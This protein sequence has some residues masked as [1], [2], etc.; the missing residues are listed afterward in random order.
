MFGIKRDWRQSARKTFDK[1][2]HAA[3]AFLVGGAAGAAVRLTGH[4]ALA[5]FFTTT[6]SILL[7]IGAAMTVGAFAG[8]TSRLLTTALFDRDSRTDHYWKRNAFLRGAAVGAVGGGFGAG[9]MDWFITH[10]YGSALRAF[11][12]D[13]LPGFFSSPAPSPPPP[14]IPQTFSPQPPPVLEIPELPQPTNEDFVSAKAA[15]SPDALPP[16][17]SEQ[18]STSENTIPPMS[19]TPPSEQV[20][21]VAGNHLSSIDQILTKDQLAMLPNRVRQFADSQDPE[22]LIWFC[23]EASF[24]LING[25]NRSAETIQVGAQL[26]KYG[27]DVAKEFSIENNITRML[28]A[29][30]SYT[31]AWGIGTAQSKDIAID[32]A[33]L[34]GRAVNNYGGRL[35]ALFKVAPAPAPT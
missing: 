13:K 14:Q 28:H 11:L 26:I 35:L 9:V 2:K 23:K 24:Y 12:N 10:G 19:S 16:N 8:G 33:Q 32:E 5:A 7:T 25:K 22:K 34:A 3:P 21:A 31:T 29:D 1:I 4:F 15:P 20:L 27:L 6:P 30:R 17:L 18:G